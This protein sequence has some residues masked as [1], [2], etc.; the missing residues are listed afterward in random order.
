MKVSLEIDILNK[1]QLVYLLEREFN[2]TLNTLKKMS[3][4]DLKSMLTAI[5]QIR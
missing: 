4:D 2:R 3:R 1:S 5:L